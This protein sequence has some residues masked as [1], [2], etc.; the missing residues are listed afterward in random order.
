LFS[1]EGPTGQSTTAGP[2]SPGKARGFI[3]SSAFVGLLTDVGF[4]AVAQRAKTV[5]RLQTQHAGLGARFSFF[6]FF[7]LPF[8]ALPSV[9]FLFLLFSRARFLAGGATDKRKQKKA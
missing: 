6:F 3:E 9:F 4:D 5:A 2:T 7:L 1:G 8:F